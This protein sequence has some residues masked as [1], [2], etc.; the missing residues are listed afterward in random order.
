MNAKQTASLQHLAGL[1]EL[2][3][4]GRDASSQCCYET[5]GTDN[6]IQLFQMGV[7]DA[8][9]KHFALLPKWHSITLRETN[10]SDKGFRHLS[11][12]DQLR[13][14]DVAE[15]RITSLYPI[16]NAIHLEKLWVDRLESLNDRKAAALKNFRK[17]QFLDLGSTGIFDATLKHLEGMDDLRKL[18]LVHTKITDEGLRSV[19]TL[20][21]LEM[22]GLYAT[23]VSDDGLRHLHAIDSLRLLVIGD[24]NVTAKG[25]K[26]I[27]KAIPGLKVADYEGIY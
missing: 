3:R 11:N 7:T 15:T 12:Q 27:K 17:L 23:K 22:L 19:G 25:K 9:M 14:L 10:V 6:G 5:N 21:S 1:T 2:G 13:F 18:N 20:P 4:I 24:T 26:E 8:D 16:R